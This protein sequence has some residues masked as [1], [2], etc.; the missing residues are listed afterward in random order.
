M[1]SEEFLNSKLR[2]EQANLDIL[3]Q[4]IID[5]KERINIE[6]KGN[7]N[8]T[9]IDIAYKCPNL[10]EKR[11]LLISLGSEKKEIIV[12]PEYAEG[13]LTLILSEEETNNSIDFFIV[14]NNVSEKIKLRS[15]E[16]DIEA[17]ILLESEQNPKIANDDSQIMLISL[18]KNFEVRPYS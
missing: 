16:T 17:E 1:E 10:R 14:E 4:N 11:T 6:S 18:R 3:K 12:T 7:S 8:Q 13:D 15:F 5:E 9:I 2:E